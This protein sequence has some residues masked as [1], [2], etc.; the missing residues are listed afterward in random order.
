MKIV[1]DTNIVISAALGSNTC[2]TAILKAFSQKY[3]VIEPPIISLELDRFLYKLQKKVGNNIELL[4]SIEAF[5]RAFLASVEIQSPAKIR[6]ISS[7]KPDNHFLSLA[8]E[9]SAL[10]ITGDKLAVECGKKAGIL[11]MTPSEF[12]GV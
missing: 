11:T 12:L 9:E 7:D 5:F 10:F 3:F 1:I 8:I 6:N 4:K 2:K